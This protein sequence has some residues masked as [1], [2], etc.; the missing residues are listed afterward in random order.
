MVSAVSFTGPP[1]AEQSQ[2]ESLINGMIGND[3]FYWLTIHA[4]RQPAL[5]LLGVPKDVQAG[6][7]PRDHANMDQILAAMLP[8]SNRLAGILVDQNRQLPPADTLEEIEVPALVIHARDDTLVDF[9]Q[10]QH[11]AEHIPSAQFMRLESGGHFQM[12][13]PDPANQGVAGF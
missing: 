4:A 13:H 8:M 9:S 1:T 12:G 11:T 3:F 10:G 6:L 7:D 2:T 5:A